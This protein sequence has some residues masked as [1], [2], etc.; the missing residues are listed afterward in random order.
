VE[1]VAIEFDRMK[2]RT[3]GHE[4]LCDDNQ[5]KS[6]WNEQVPAA[7][8]RRDPGFLLP[9]GRFRALWRTLGAK[10]PSRETF[11]RLRGAYDESHRAYHTARHIGACLRILDDSA[12][13]A[14]AER[15]EEVEAALWFHDAVYDTRA[16]DNEE[17]SAMLAEETLRTGGVAVDVVTRIASY[18]RAT[19]DHSTETPDGRLVMDVDLAILGEDTATYDRFEQGIRA[20]YGWVDDASYAVARAGVLRHFE[21]RPFIYATRVLRDRLESRARENLAASLKRVAQPPGSAGRSGPV[22]DEG[23]SIAG[24]VRALCDAQPGGAAEVLAR[25]HPLV[26][27]LLGARRFSGPLLHRNP[28]LPWPEILEGAPAGIEVDYAALS[29]NG[30]SFWTAEILRRHADA[31]DWS[32]LSGNEHLPW[33]RDLVADFADRWIWKVMSSNPA[34]PWSGDLVGAFSDRWVF[35]RLA[36]N[37]RVPWDKGLLGRYRDRLAER[38]PDWDPWM[39]S[40]RPVALAPGITLGEQGWNHLWQ[41]PGASW[42]ELLGSLESADWSALSSNPGVGWDDEAIARHA[43][44]IDFGRLAANRGVAF[45][46]AL[47][48]RYADRWN[49]PVLSGNPSLPWSDAFLRKNAA[50]WSWQRISTNGG[51]PWTEA[52]LSDLEDRLRWDHRGLSSA[53]RLDRASLMRFAPKLDWN[54]GVTTNPVIAWSR[55]IVA[56]HADRWNW[57]RLGFNPELPWTD[58]L[59][60]EFS[61]RWVLGSFERNERAWEAIGPHLDDAFLRAWVRRHPG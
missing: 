33:S 38:D 47:V 11:M 42:G 56:D 44:T 48:E 17:Q 18:I 21:D 29:S 12:V 14:L 19:H 59:V 53:A 23:A 37:H 60:A 34:L 51:V 16:T 31:W 3:C 43:H 5:I 15:I 20:E 50:R 9:E 45:T 8:L 32:A 30:G 22:P 26:L 41:N 35:S 58:A 4:E 46:E 54:W 49:W 7:P 28:R 39:A 52:L 25:H 24:A 61:D 55:E 27:E 36:A 1:P 10:G 13:R 2:C 6:D 40:E 57:E